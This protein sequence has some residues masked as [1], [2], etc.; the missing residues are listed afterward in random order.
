MI[1]CSY[2]IIIIVKNECFSIAI[3]Q[4]FSYNLFK[5]ISKVIKGDISMFIYLIALALLPTILLMIF[6]YYKDSHEKE[7]VKLLAT[8][9]LGGILSIIPAVIIEELGHMIIV[10]FFSEESFMY[11]LLYAFFVVAL[12]EE[13]GKFIF[14]YAISWN[15]K[16]FNYKFDGI[17][18]CVFVS[19][20]FATL[21]NLLYVFEGGISTG[22]LRAIL[23]VPS[24]A[25]DAVFMGYFYSKAK[26]S[27]SVGDKSGKALNLLLALTVAIFLHGF[28]DFCLFVA[29]PFTIILFLIFVV[30]MDIVA[31]IRIHISSKKNDEIFRNNYNNVYGNIYVPLNQNINHNTPNYYPQYNQ[32]AQYQNQ[33]GFG[34]QQ[35]NP[36]FN[37]HNSYWQQTPYQSGPA[38][39]YQPPYQPSMQAGHVP[40][41]VSNQ[42]PFN[43]SQNGRIGVP[44]NFR[45]P[46]RM[47]YCTHCG[48]LCN[49]EMFYC[50]SCG[51]PMHRHNNF[52]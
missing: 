38:T 45:G 43:P 2:S 3:M 31:F 52:H 39:P 5:N 33:A 19:L 17:V 36:Q 14:A 18:Y 40:H 30:I 29:T 20:G 8:L 6:I 4:S 26:V 49:S 16:H 44:H 28:Y 7:P 46:V 34:M 51:N 50:T 48:N 32:P 11:N 42:M 41:Q 10:P 21:E 24:H 1:Y 47:I 35:Y 23:S 22:I 12:A 37:S 9:F 27:E 25:I 15:N 13:G